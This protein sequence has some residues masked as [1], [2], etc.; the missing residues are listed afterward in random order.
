MLTSLEYKFFRSIPAFSSLKDQSLLLLTKEMSKQK[1]IKGEYFFFQDE[2]VEKL[3]I[4]E[5]GTVEIFKSDAKGK[6]LTLWHIESGNAFCL[7]NIFAGRSF[8]NARAITDCLAFSLSRKKLEKILAQDSDIS[9]HFITCISSKLAAYSSL[10]EDFSFKKIQERLINLLIKSS[11]PN[12]DDD[13]YVCNLSQNEIA[14][15]LGTCREVVSRTLS[16]MKIDGLIQTEK[17]QNQNLIVI[18]DYKKLKVISKE[19]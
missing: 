16:K 7:A 8:A 3:Y 1:T 2:P 19:F 17:K 18:P 4:L 9:K 10:L 13:K 12:E 5:M 6:K 11:T 15:R 14:S